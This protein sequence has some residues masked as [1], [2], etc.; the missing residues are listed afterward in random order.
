MRWKYLT[1]YYRKKYSFGKI[2]PSHNA[3]KSKFMIKST[4]LS[5]LQLCEFP[6]F[7]I[8]ATNNIFEEKKVLL[9]FILWK[10]IFSNKPSKTFDSVGEEGWTI[11]RPFLPVYEQDNKCRIS[12]T[13][14]R[15]ILYCPFSVKLVLIVCTI[16]LLEYQHEHNK[17]F[18]K[19]FLLI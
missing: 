5:Y 19:S 15:F 7:W 10:I 17:L 14:V 16:L 4:S 6:S 11:L 8:W 13:W 9:V 3:V 18:L 1:G 2:V 12:P